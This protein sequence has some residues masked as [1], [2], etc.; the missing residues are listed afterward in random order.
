[1]QIEERIVF[2][3]D[4]H[5]VLVHSGQSQNFS[6]LVHFQFLLDH[7]PFLVV[8]AG[9]IHL[10]DPF[11]L[12]QFVDAGLIKVLLGSPSGRR[13]FPEVDPVVETL[14]PLRHNFNLKTSQ[15]YNSQLFYQSDHLGSLLLRDF[16]F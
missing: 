11:Q 7:L 6:L 14:L 8:H 2:V 10:P 9:P 12:L 5:V 15:A 13:S 1:M 4:H 3:P 16:L